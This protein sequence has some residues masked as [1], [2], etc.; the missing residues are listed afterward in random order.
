MNISITPEPECIDNCVKVKACC[1]TIRWSNRIKVIT[2]VVV[3]DLCI[4]LPVLDGIFPVIAGPHL[5][6]LQF[7]N[8]NLQRDIKTKRVRNLQNGKFDGWLIKVAEPD[9]VFFSHFHFILTIFIGNGSATGG[10][11]YAHQFKRVIAGAIVHGAA[12]LILGIAC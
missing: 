7:R 10:G 4:I 2:F 1:L 12:D 5:H 9:R 6:F 3:E 8:A 11:K